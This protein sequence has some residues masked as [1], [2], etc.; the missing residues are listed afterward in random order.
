MEYFKNN[1]EFNFFT[2][3]SLIAVEGRQESVQDV[4]RKYLIN[5]ALQLKRTTLNTLFG[6]NFSFL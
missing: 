2:D 4:T 1:Y 6:I 3:T 5:L